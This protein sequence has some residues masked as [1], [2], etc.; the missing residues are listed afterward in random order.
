MAHVRHTTLVVE[1]EGLSSNPEARYP[2]PAGIDTEVSSSSILDSGKI[3]ELDGSATSRGSDNSSSNSTRDYTSSSDHDSSERE[4]KLSDV[5]AGRTDDGVEGEIIS[6]GTVDAKENS[7]EN[8]ENVEAN[9][10]E[11]VGAKPS[12]CFMGQSLMTQTELDSLVSKGCFSAVACRPSGKE[13]TP[14]SKPNECMV[15]HDFFT[16][17]LRLTTSKRFT[18]LQGSN[19]SA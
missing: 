9:P 7:G 8:L 14:E 13:T 6:S 2:P 18:G 15:F 16:I 12:T 4:M 1:N 17:R 19:P 10:N 3:S 11:L 5:D